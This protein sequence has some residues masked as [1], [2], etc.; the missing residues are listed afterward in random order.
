MPYLDSEGNEFC[1]VAIATQIRAMPGYHYHGSKLSIPTRTMLCPSNKPLKLDYYRKHSVP[2]RILYR[3][4]HP[5]H[6]TRSY[7]GLLTD[8]VLPYPRE[9]AARWDHSC[10]PF[11][12]LD[13]Q[14]LRQGVWKTVYQSESIVLRTI[15]VFAFHRD[16]VLLH[17]LSH[18]GANRDAGGCNQ[19]CTRGGEW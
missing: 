9:P 19:A 14:L 17:L 1:H 8:D 2:S 16:K 3:G 13:I 15:P 6:A 11:N 10:K 7:F 18:F 12:V 5:L 4:N